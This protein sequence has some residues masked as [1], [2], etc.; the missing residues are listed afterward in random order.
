MRYFVASFIALLF[1]FVS[2]ASPYKDSLLNE[3]NIAIK[4]SGDYDNKKLQVIAGL[5]QSLIASRTINIVGR[6]A[7]LIR[8]YDEYKYY[9]YDS[10]YNCAN[11][12]RRFAENQHDPSLLADAKLKQVFILLSGGMF[13]ETFDS[14]NAISIQNAGDLVKAEFFTLKARCYYDLGDF[15]EDDLHTPFYYN[16]ANRKY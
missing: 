4:Q 13:K 7:I 15:D 8:L 1:C 3:L 14:L 6:Y 12:L 16:L 10:A 9:N 2:L 5:K 11:Q